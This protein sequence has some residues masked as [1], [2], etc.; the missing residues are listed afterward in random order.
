MEQMRKY[1]YLL[2]LLCGGT[3]ED[4]RNMSPKRYMQFL[5]ES[6]RFIL[7]TDYCGSEVIVA[8]EQIEHIECE[9]YGI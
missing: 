5:K 2:H 4:I 1:R 6:E 8:K 3:V 7:C 9:E